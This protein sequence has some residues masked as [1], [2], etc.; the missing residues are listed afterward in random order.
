MYNTVKLVCR[1]EKNEDYFGTGFIYIFFRNELD[2]VPVIVSNT[3]V[4]NDAR[5]IFL[6]L[7][8][9]ND[10]NQPIPGTRSTFRIIIEEE[11]KKK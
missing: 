7:H 11:Q 6:T 9:S 1:N 4:L 8:A 3:H 2:S 5:I 10:M